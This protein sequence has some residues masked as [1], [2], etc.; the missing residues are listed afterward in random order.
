LRALSQYVFDL[1]TADL[2]KPESSV[3]VADELVKRQDTIDLPILN[4]G[5]SNNNDRK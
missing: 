5:M 1:L 3:T 4:A 2:A